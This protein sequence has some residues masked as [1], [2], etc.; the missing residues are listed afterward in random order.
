MSALLFLD[1]GLDFGGKQIWFLK[2]SLIS[3]G[4]SA[5]LIGG[6]DSMSDA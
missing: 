1:Q 5:Y 6:Y 4:N 3:Q 2:Q